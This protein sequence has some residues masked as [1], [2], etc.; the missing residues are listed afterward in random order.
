MKYNISLILAVISILLI[1]YLLFFSIKEGFD[2]ISQEE[3]FEKS[4]ELYFKARENDGIPS[5]ESADMFYDYNFSNDKLSVKKPDEIRAD[6][7][8]YEPVDQAVEQCKKITS[9]DELDGTSCGYC[10]YNNRFYYGDENGPKTD[11]C[12]GGWVKT[13]EAC[14]ERRERAICDKVTS[15]HNMIGDAA[16]CAWCP[17][18]NKAFVYKKENGKVVPKY[19]KDVCIDTDLTTGADL[20]LV[21]QKECSAFEKDHP[22]IG[23]NENTGPHSQSCLNHLWKEGGCPASGKHAP[24]NDEHSRNWWNQRGWKVVLSDMKAWFSDANSSNWNTAKTHHEG[25]YGTEPD[26][27]D[28]KYGGTLECYQKKFIEAGCTKK[29]SAYPTS[30]PSMGISNYENQVKTMISNSHNS[31][32]DFTERNKAYNGCYGGELR[33]PPPMKVGDRVSYRVKVGSGHP[34]VCADSEENSMIEFT[35]YICGESGSNKKVIWDTVT[36]TNPA[37]RC[38][39]KP[40]TWNKKNYS[41]DIG[42]ITK[43]LG[44]C[45]IAPT[46]FNNT[47]KSEIDG[48]S[49]NLVHSCNSTTSCDDA[50]CG[51]QNIVYIH[52]PQTLYSVPKNKVSEIISTTRGVFNSTKLASVTDIQYLVD[53]GIPYCACGWV[54]QNGQVT[55]SYPSVIGTD[56]GCG[57]GAERVI[58]CGSTGTSGVYARIDAD[59]SK[60]PAELKKVGITA[61]VVA[62]VGKNEYVSLTG[63][64]KPKQLNPSDYVMYGPD[65][66][67]GKEIPILKI[68]QED[69]KIVYITHDGRFTKIV[70]AN[71]DGSDQQ[72]FYYV[73]QLSQYGSKPLRNMV[74]GGYNVKR[75]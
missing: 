11:V 30:K 17:T 59:P 13:K 20:G 5:I 19:S 73:G 74:K 4:E 71:P 63:N 8:K 62:T 47:V 54:N 48:K 56:K 35:G 12:P 64:F 57:D 14:V 49:L 67:G 24:D 31:S 39:S 43:Y 28:P 10:F 15:C 58:N 32:L 23:P 3:D 36:N 72:G 60:I 7:G 22:C 61:A 55:K 68:I 21:L 38:G 44:F 37:S 6:A 66:G 18:K 26:P 41:T 65:I 53:I 25:C 45:G 42:W 40:L 2:V 16:I 69:G 1:V 51:L 52:Y 9:C 27:C 34:S 33:A 70:K 29:G 75:K 46:Y 50:G